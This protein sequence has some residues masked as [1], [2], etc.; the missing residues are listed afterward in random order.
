MTNFDV[1][2]FAR[3][4][5]QVM[6][7][8]Y[9]EAHDQ[10]WTAL[11]HEPGTKAELWIHDDRG[12]ARI[13][14]GFDVLQKYVRY[15]RRGQNEIT[16]DP[17]RPLARI[18]ADIERRLLP[19]Y[20]TDLLYVQKCDDEHHARMKQVANAALH[21]AA[22]LQVA[23]PEVAEEERARF[24]LGHIGCVYG[25]IEID[26]HSVEMKLDDVPFALA[27]MML[28]PIAEYVQRHQ[29]PSEETDE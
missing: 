6:N 7:W 15:E 5:A 23:P 22:I 3:Q 19:D 16:V 1:H 14:G 8:T 9:D 29:E 12:R 28:V 18:K 2:G 26:T 24:H 10:S 11:I 20:R 21:F 4:L 17:K 25:T 13:S 27:A